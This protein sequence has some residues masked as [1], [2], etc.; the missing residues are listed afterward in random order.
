MSGDANLEMLTPSRKRLNVGDVFALKPKGH[1]YYFGRVIRLDAIGLAGGAILIYI[2]NAKSDD[3]GSI[4]VLDKRHLL[5][6][7][8]MINRLPWSRGYFETVANLPLSD[9]DIL[10]PHCFEDDWRHVLFPGSP[11]IYRDEYG[12]RLP[13]R[14]EP[15][16]IYGLGSFRTVDDD[17]SEALG[18]PLAPD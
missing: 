8:T 14:T 12:N 15:C 16:G 5:I 2:Y 4:P 6:A 17:V 11:I 9:E 10:H 7:P 1:P 18:I 13:G 3:K